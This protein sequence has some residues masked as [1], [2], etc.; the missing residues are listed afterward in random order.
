MPAI[1]IINRLLPLVLLLVV[2]TAGFSLVVYQHRQH[3]RLQKKLTGQIHNATAK[4]ALGQTII[5]D[6]RITLDSYRA[7]LLAED[8][9]EQMLLQ[10][11]AFE[12]IDE[13][14]EALKLLATGGSFKKMIQLN[15]PGKEDALFEIYYKPEG[16]QTYNLEILT[17]KPQ[18]VELQEKLQE[19]LNHEGDQISRFSKEF[20]SLLIRMTEN[21]NKLT[22]DA[23]TDLHRLH[24]HFSN[25]VDA[26]EHN[27]L[28]LAILVPFSCLVLIALVFRQIFLG[29]VTLE[30]MVAELKQ[31]ETE[32]Q[33]QNRLILT[34]NE[35]LEEQVALR[36][37]ELEVSERQW[38]DAFD[39]VRSPIFLHDKDGLLIKANQAYL[40]ACNRSFANVCDKPYWQVFPKQDGS[41]PNCMRH[42]DCFDA[43]GC[44][45]ETL[46]V[47]DRVYRSQS[48]TINDEKGKYLYSLHIMDDIT[49][50]AEQEALVR[51]SAK[52]F[53]N[54]TEGIIITDKT[55][56]ILAVN[57]AFTAITGYSESEVL[58]GN[59]RLLQSGKQDLVFYQKLWR[60]LARDGHWR[61]ELWN[62]RKNGEIYPEWLTIGSVAGDNGQLENYV[63][64]FSDITSV[65]SAMAQL[66]FQAQHHPLTGLP[67]RLWLHNRLE[68]S[69]QR[70]LRENACGAV[71]FIDLDNFKHINDS[72]GHATG[73]EVLKEVAC[74]IKTITRAVDTFAHL[75]GDEFV[76]VMEQ[77]MS[78]DDV[79]RHARLLLEKLHDPFVIHSYELFLCASIGIALFPGDGVDAESLLKNS[80]AAMY[81]AKASGKNRFHF[82]SPELTAASRE[83]LHME[84]QLRR[85]LEKNELLVHYQPQMCMATGNII[86]MEALV[87]WQHP[88]MGLVP[89]GKFIPLSE[90]IG[91]IIPI[92]EWVLRTACRFFVE[93]SKSGS[94]LKRVA[95]NLS[96]R[97]LQN[98]TLP[99]T[100]SK[101][102][103][104]TGCPASALEL[105]ITEGFVMQHPEQAIQV[106]AQL[107]ELG[108]A[109]AIDDF[110][111]GHSSLNY[112]K[113]FP[114]H[115]LKIDQSFVADIGKNPEGEAITKAIIAMGQ[116]LN[117]E[118]TAE[119]IETVE[120]LDFLRDLRCEE[121]QGYLIS[122]PLSAEQF[123][124]FVAK[125]LDS[126]HPR[127]LYC[128]SQVGNR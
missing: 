94:S 15:L 4:L 47:D 8:S 28:R 104:E 13:I 92:G 70:A 48:F 90:E 42:C 21:A 81:Q 44:D 73:D 115:R 57:R 89:P 41:V 61:G 105:E 83:R 62:K 99:E 103:R 117:L 37:Q 71:L 32:L 46:T 9:A 106:L 58:G 122:K 45:E 36:T 116:I 110:G 128:L 111:T 34:F 75:S 76:L 107:R 23:R 40:Q 52:V 67:N 20:D 108:V 26:S 86:A 95:V 16:E 84:S 74:R 93:L 24:T 2:V 35:S 55:G 18:I 6:L 43:N 12:A 17:L 72:F 54:T 63:A 59:P 38:R 119:G 87:R 50:K 96:G 53:E 14:D 22:Y 51:L 27:E 127:S 78:V 77:V 30:G 25:M 91:M 88:E 82:Y 126:F 102:L 31:A 60:E 101:I 64:V 56:K 66:E 112:L 79:S 11:R 49:E 120:Q 121:A 69:I 123:A 85:V 68:H 113:R 114:V 100:V 125:P 65:K 33:Q 124:E 7:Y 118:I 5:D 97:Q 109:L 19:S 1:R 80:D 3:S 98:K 10:Q 39:A 29:R